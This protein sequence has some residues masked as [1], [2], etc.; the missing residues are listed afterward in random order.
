MS[1][2]PKSQVRVLSVLAGLLIASAILRGVSG[3][4]AFLAQA[5]TGSGPEVAEDK[6]SMAP[7]EID[8]VLA[9]FREREERIVRREAQIEDRL[10]ALRVAEA[11]IDAKI[12]ALEAA[13]QSLRDTLALA[14]SAAETDLDQLTAVYQNMK[15]KEA[16]AL[17]EE[18]APE[19]AAG[20][21]A[22][23]RPD[24]AAAIFAGLQPS[25][26]YTISVILA[27]RN[28]DVPTE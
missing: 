26:A 16:A 1:E 24:A 27:G 8:E 18:M 19:F 20:F 5:E 25:T 6:M 22:R 4:D 12:I 23:M 10:Q 11:E 17:F 28:A 7:D 13:E 9:G 14:A 15:P 2:M 3:V 21:L